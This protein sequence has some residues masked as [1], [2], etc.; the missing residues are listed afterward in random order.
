M[1]APRAGDRDPISL[2]GHMDDVAAGALWL[3]FGIW[4]TGVKIE[5]CPT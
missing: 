5:R 2:Q 4:L 3:I 1:F